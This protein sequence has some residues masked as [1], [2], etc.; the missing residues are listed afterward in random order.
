MTDIDFV[1]LMERY[2]DSYEPMSLLK[3]LRDLWRTL[4]KRP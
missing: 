1:V 4:F 2:R 3:S